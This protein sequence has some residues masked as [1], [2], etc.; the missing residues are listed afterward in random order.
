MPVSRRIEIARVFNAPR[1]RVYLALTD[2]DHLAEW[3]G[4][5]DCSVPRDSVEIDARPGG[6]L[7]FVITGPGMRSR[8]DAV[9]TEVVENELLAAD[10][11]VNGAP[12]VAG[13]LRMQLRLELR[14][15]GSGKTRL[16]LRQGPFPAA[17]I[18]ADAH[19]GWESS[20]AKLEAML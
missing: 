10:M 20:F 2:P 6:H 1:E 7:R 11:E 13:P 4:P 5:A 16:E 9:F 12:G 15:E 17:Q 3:L 19:G 14:D 18:G 8:V